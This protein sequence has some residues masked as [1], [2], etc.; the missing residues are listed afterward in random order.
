MSCIDK[1]RVLRAA[2]MVVAQ[3]PEVGQPGP[4]VVS[5]LTGYGRAAIA[6]PLPGLYNP[7]ADPLKT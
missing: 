2:G 6:N 5:Q 3:L 1:L 4:A 7:S